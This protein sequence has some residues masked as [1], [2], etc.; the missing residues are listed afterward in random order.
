MT[1]TKRR[2]DVRKALD[3][4]SAKYSGKLTPE[5]VLKEAKPES[6]PLHDE[7]T[8]DNS[9]AGHLYR[10][11]QAKQLIVIYSIRKVYDG[12]ASKKKRSFFRVQVEEGKPKEWVRSI[13]VMSNKELTHSAA[14]EAF[15]QFKRAVHL[16][17]PFPQYF[18]ELIEI[19]NKA[20][21]EVKLNR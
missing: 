17:E 16:L 8:W 6:S 3:E 7:F 15:N 4:I 13:E 14:V 20:I 2:P 1:A 21:A 19:V 10:L 12:T 9:R 18:T 5:I 11:E